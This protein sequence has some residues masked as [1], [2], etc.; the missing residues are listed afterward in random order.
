[1]TRSRH[2]FRTLRSG[3]PVVAVGC[4]LSA[5]VSAQSPVGYASLRAAAVD[6]SGEAGG[7]TLRDQGSRIG[8][9]GSLFAP[10]R[11]VGFPYRVE[12]GVDTGNALRDDDEQV[13]VLELRLA[14]V[15]VIG[16][17][18]ELHLGRQ[19]SPYYNFLSKFTD[20]F[21]LDNALAL[22][23]GGTCRADVGRAD[24][25]PERDA[26]PAGD[27][28]YRRLDFALS[29]ALPLTDAIDASFRSR[30]GLESQ[31]AVGNDVWSYG[32][33]F[34]SPG[35]RFGLPVQHV[36]LAFAGIR[37]TD[38]GSYSHGATAGLR[39]ADGLDLGITFERFAIDEQADGHAVKIAAVLHDLARWHERAAA[40]M[41]WDYLLVKSRLKLGFE[42]RDLTAVS[43]APDGDTMDYYVGWEYEHSPGLTF[44]LEFGSRDRGG[45]RANAVGFYLQYD[46]AS[47]YL[48][49]G[50]R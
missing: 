7:L 30:H 24:G 11:Q 43:A 39:T 48:P 20:V 12:L 46:W 44:A 9:R 18:G 29:Y 32:G 1:M 25:C 35:A 45:R 31:L 3:L 4:V 49:V 27:A 37:N 26:T 47:D 10:R 42:H 34:F 2:L 6:G 17:Y 40:D 41:Y 8:L 5:G 19:W 21:K 38:D 50:V 23:D 28:D 15:G 22:F 33:G 13:D 16:D 14:R 36:G